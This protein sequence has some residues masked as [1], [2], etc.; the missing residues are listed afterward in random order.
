MTEFIRER[1][2]SGLNTSGVI[3]VIEYA[4]I[5]RVIKDLL[6]L[7]DYNLDDEWENTLWFVPLRK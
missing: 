2:A 3:V 4:P 6:Y 5:G 7:M 1:I